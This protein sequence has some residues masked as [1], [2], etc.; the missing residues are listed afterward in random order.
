MLSRIQPHFLYN[1]LTS[2]IYYADKDPGK[3]KTALVDFSR[4]LRKNLEAIS[5]EGPVRF[6]DEL[7][8]TKKYLALEKLR[9]EEKLKIVYEIEDRD[10][11]LPVLTLQPLV[12]NAVKHGIRKNRDGTGQVTIRTFR[13][14]EKHVI[15]VIDDGVGF[16][17]ESLSQSDDTHIGVMNVKKRL[18][19]E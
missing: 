9:F 4:Y 12:E 1:S 11:S 8:H 5:A 15:E 14:A 17:V 13:K 18:G 16:D 3:T 10:F 6:E 7:E 2:I 19:M